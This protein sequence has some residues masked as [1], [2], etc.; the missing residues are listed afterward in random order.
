VDIFFG[1][2]EAGHKCVSVGFYVLF[3]IGVA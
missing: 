3:D 1:N 2:K